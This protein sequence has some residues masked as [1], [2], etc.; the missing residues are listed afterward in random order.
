MGTMNHLE[1]LKRLLPSVPE[2]PPDNDQL[3]QL[4][5]ADDTYDSAAIRQD[6]ENGLRSIWE[7]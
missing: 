3:T 5:L 1:L 2:V 7:S 6:I 4:L